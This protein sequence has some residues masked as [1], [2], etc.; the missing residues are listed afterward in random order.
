MRRKYTIEFA[1]QYFK[2]EGCELLEEKY[3]SAKT[4]MKY[5][6]NCGNISEIT[7]S[8]FKQGRRCRKCGAKKSI[9]SRKFTTEEVKNYFKE[10]G[11]ELLEEE[12]K[13]NYTKMRYRCVCGEISEICLNNFKN[14][15]RCKK[16]GNKKI[17]NSHKLIFKDVYD[18]FEE[19]GCEL[20]EKKY[21]NNRTKM[22][23]KCSCGN[24]SEITFDYF[25]QGYRCEKCGE[26]KMHSFEYIKQCFEEQGC[27]LL[28][29]EYKGCYAK[30]RYICS[31]GYLSKIDFCH[32]KIGKR[33]KRCGIE[34]MSGKNNH[35]Y[36]PNLT[37][38]DRGDRRLIDGYKKW[39]KNTY[40]KDTYTC[41]K[42]KE[43]KDSNGKYKK[44]NA[45]HIEGYAE[46]PDL[47]IDDD[48]GITLCVACHHSFH[49]I[50][51]K[52]NV[53]RQQLEEFLKFIR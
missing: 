21:I 18:Q 31:C 43:R 14:G 38:E 25:K 10:Q 29:T 40:K 17:S 37:D 23:Y 47:R 2:D 33:C 22:K 1:K 12:Y 53:N 16:C 45:H 50:Y 24:I 52:K 28:E 8:S 27:K 48:N 3:I 19:Q 42:C 26:G 11:C 15:A 41:Q 39:A 4:K 36:N 32:F 46:N 35:N 34:K 13:N 30:M 7:F 44:L 6:C 51:G 49:S 20:L 5:K 9:E